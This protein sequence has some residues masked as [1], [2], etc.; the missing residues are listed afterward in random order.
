MKMTKEPMEPMSG[1]DMK[2][3]DDFVSQHEAGG[4]KHHKHEFKK[5]AAGFKHHMDGVMAMCGG[6]MG[7]GKKAK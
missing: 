7:Y 4:H 2:R 6:G 5:H 3:N 1:P